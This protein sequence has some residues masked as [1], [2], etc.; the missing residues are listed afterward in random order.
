[1]ADGSGCRIFADAEC[2]GES[3]SLRRG[4]GGLSAEGESE[5]A[6]VSAGGGAAAVA[7][8]IIAG[9]GAG[10][11]SLVSTSAEMGS[12]SLVGSLASMRSATAK[13]QN[14][15]VAKPSFR[16][17]DLSGDKAVAEIVNKAKNPNSQK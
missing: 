6:G 2:R 11:E 4:A 9:A 8:G 12:G 15:R 10:L 7:G 17:D 1:M 16:G 13:S 3:D 14:G 5:C